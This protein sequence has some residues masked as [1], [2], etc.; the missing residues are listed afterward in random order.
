MK[1][2]PAKTNSALIAEQ[3]NFGGFVRH[4]EF[5][6]RIRSE[7]SKK[8]RNK[9][10]AFLSMRSFDSSLVFFNKNAFI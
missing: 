3:V 8:F 10:E 2:S 1:L 6:A 4:K 9:I 7:N 5:R